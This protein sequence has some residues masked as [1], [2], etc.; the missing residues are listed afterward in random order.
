ML[1]NLTLHFNYWFFILHAKCLEKCLHRPRKKQMVIPMLLLKTSFGSLKLTGMPNS[2]LM[3]L[4][5]TPNV[6]KNVYIGQK[7]QMVVPML[8]FRTSFGSLKLTGM[9]ISDLMWC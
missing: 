7:K 1:E 3:W 8:L 4:F 9:P 2:D 6:E 5:Y